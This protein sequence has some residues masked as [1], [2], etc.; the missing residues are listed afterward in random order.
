MAPN[1]VAR[2]FKKAYKLHD[3]LIRPAQVVV[4]VPVSPGNGENSE[5]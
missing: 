3:K 1:H 4:S 5:T 2:V